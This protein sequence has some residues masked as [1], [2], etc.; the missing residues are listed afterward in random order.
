MN[1]NTSQINLV[2]IIPETLD[3]TRLDL[4][5]STLLPEYS[6]ARIQEWIRAGFVTIDGKILRP[7][8]KVHVNQTVNIAATITNIT[9]SEAQPIALDV[10]YEDKDIIVINKPAGLVTHPGAGNAD[11]TL[12]N[13]LLYRYP[14][15]AKLPR[16]G[17]IH[18]LDKDTSGLMVVTRNLIAHNKL[19]AALQKR[20]IK[21]EYEAIVNGEMIAG[22]T[23]EAPIGRHPFKRTHM[24]VKENGK[25]AVTHYRIIKRFISYTHI[26]VILETGRTHQIRVHLAHIG[27][28]IVGDPNYSNSKN[29][30]SEKF[31]PALRHKIEQFGRQALHARHLELQHPVTGRLMVWD[32]KPPKDFEELLE[33]LESYVVK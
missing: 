12:L 32:A 2:K 4:A 21:R 13:A 19:V 14:E 16:A 3:Q 23:I 5:L 18:R 17:I 28:P 24:A 27:Y 22:G 33:A 15:L 25:L 31:N 26:R 11:K 6:R 9:Q 1:I 30:I 10:V 7:K 8:D 20:E 29:K